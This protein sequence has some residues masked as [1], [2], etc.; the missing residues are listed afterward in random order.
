MKNS[1]KKSSK[2]GGNKIK[3]IDVKSE[4]VQ[5]D[6]DFETAMLEMSFENL[7]GLMKTLGIPSPQTKKIKQQARLIAMFNQKMIE[8]GHPEQVINMGEKIMPWIVKISTAEMFMEPLGKWMM[9]MVG[10]KKGTHK[11]VEKTK[12]MRA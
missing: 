7:A 2:K 4:R 10:K 11:I 1:P 12:S 8:S 5:I 6:L 9:E 3:N